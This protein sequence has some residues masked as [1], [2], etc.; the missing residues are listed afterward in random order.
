MELVYKGK[1]KDVYKNE[2]GNY[3]LKF[4]D[5]ATGVDGVFDPGA[6]TVG[7]TIEGLGNDALKLTDFF[8]TRL[9]KMGVPT[10]FI[11]S[12]IANGTMEVKP[13][14]RFGKGL[15]V[16]CRLKA[17]GSFFRRYGDF[18]TEGQ[19]L[20]YFVEVTLKD[21]AREDPPISKDALAMLNIVTEEQYESLKADTVKITKIVRD[22]LAEKGVELYDIKFEFGV[23]N[24]K[25]ILIDEIS[26]GNMRAK[27]D[28]K[29][30]EPL[31]YAPIIVG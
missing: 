27:K 29:F 24:G 26:G 1:T 15:E 16:I 8:Y 18:C 9:E 22:I 23:N 10:H 4:K 12:D 6:N 20:D 3:V 30:L 25:V 7:V 13:A 28:G 14:E 11:A 5:D 17:V 19:D 21:D 2:K 31:E